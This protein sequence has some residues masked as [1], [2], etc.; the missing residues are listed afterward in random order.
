MFFAVGVAR[1]LVVDE[2]A[3]LLDVSKFS[4]L[5]HGATTER[6]QQIG[7]AIKALAEVMSVG[8]LRWASGT[9]TW[10][11]RSRFP[12]AAPIKAYVIDVAPRSPGEHGDHVQ[13]VGSRN[14]LID[15][16]SPPVLPAAWSETLASSRS[17]GKRRWHDHP[18]PRLGAE[19]GSRQL[20][21]QTLD[22]P[23]RQGSATLQFARSF[24]GTTGTPSSN[25]RSPHG[26]RRHNCSLFPPG[27]RRNSRKTHEQ[28]KQRRFTIRV[29]IGPRLPL[30]RS[31][32][33]PSL[34][35]P[36]LVPGSQHFARLCWRCP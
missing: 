6:F 35:P 10:S 2:V 30:A 34:P 27:R 29:I 18:A 9:Q 22:D 26:N 12:A 3:R 25:W 32:F 33:E 23:D 31:R 16:S 8:S 14:C 36:R 15:S 13:I 20:V 19:R 28:S 7:A 5:A 17:N 24:S 21:F 1:D 4:G 11:S